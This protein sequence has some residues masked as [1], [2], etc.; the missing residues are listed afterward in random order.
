MGQTAS[1][2]DAGL[3][4]AAH[5]W[6]AYMS[7][8]AIRRVMHVLPVE[9]SV[10]GERVRFRQHSGV[11]VE[12]VRLPAAKDTYQRRDGDGPLPM[13][14]R[15]LARQELPGA[16]DMPHKILESADTVLVRDPVSGATATYGLK[17]NVWT[18]DQSSV[19]SLVASTR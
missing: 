4:A 6:P 11:Y 5:G 12:Y 9:K 2:E 3:A 16:G 18:R 19:R 1:R 13:F 15:H 7:T 14:P 17:N 8:T 10:L